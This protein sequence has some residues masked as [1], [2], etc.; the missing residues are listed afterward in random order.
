[1]ETQC[2]RCN[3]F[4]SRTDGYCVSCGWYMA[5]VGKYGIR[6]DQSGESCTKEI[7]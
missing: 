6:I 4:E 5:F 7:T 3:K 2:K 1:M